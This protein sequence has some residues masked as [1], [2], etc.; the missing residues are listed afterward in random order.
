V[1]SSSSRNSGLFISALARPSLAFMPMEYSSKGL[2][3]ASQRS[4]DFSSS[5][6]RLCASRLP[7][8]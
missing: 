8:P 1:G 6:A 3:R 5:S 4:T 2:W 7:S